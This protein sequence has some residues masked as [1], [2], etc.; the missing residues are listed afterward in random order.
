V[1]TNEQR[2]AR[3]RQLERALEL[4][5]TKERQS[6]LSDVGPSWPRSSVIGAS[7]PPCVVTQSATPEQDSVD[8]NPT[9]IAIRHAR[10]AGSCPRSRRGQPGRQLP[11]PGGDGEG[12][13]AETNAA[14]QGP[15]EPGAVS[16]SMVT[17]GQY[18]AAARQRQVAVHGQNS[19]RSA[20]PIRAF[21]NDT[22]VPTRRPV[23]GV[24]VPA[25]RR[26]RTT[27]RHRRAGR[28][29]S[30]RVHDSPV[31]ARRSKRGRRGYR[32]ARWRWPT[33]APEPMAAVLP[34]ATRIAAAPNYTVF[35]HIDQTGLAR[36]TNRRGRHRRGSRTASRR[37]TLRSSRDRSNESA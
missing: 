3:E 4:R 17:I 34:G 1:P 5:A 14:Q 23:R 6:R 31:H 8:A 25:V 21:F 24:A 35:R 27:A 16:A 18:R 22:T 29:S 11:V 13:Q 9:D 33:R 2:R 10:C 7:W 30:T 32:E 26:A 12:E 19:I 28:P 20:W 37:T 36:W 15:T